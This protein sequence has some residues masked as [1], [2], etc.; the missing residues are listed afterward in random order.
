[1]IFL[2]WR[3]GVFGGVF[4]IKNLMRDIFILKISYS[5]LLPITKTPS[6]KPYN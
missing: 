1:M 4:L 5:K 3:G 2:I 6:Q